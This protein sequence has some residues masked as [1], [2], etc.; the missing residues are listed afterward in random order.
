MTQRRA[1]AKPTIKLKRNQSE[2]RST[3]GYDNKQAMVTNAA[4]LSPI[5]GPML[6]YSLAENGDNNAIDIQG[7]ATTTPTQIG[8]TE[9]RARAVASNG[10]SAP[11]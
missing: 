1:I 11:S 3:R 8:L 9:R 5:L 2:V 7:A 4:V 10:P 6:L